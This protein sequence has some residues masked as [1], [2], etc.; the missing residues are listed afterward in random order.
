M[1]SQGVWSVNGV[2]DAAD[3]FKI[4]EKGK[5]SATL[6][7][8]SEHAYPVRY[9]QINRKKH[10]FEIKMDELHNI[11]LSTFKDFVNVQV[12]IHGRGSTV[13]GLMGEFGTGRLL[14]RDGRT[15]LQDINAFGQV[16]QVKAEEPKLFR[17]DRAP[18][19]PH[20]KCRLPRAS[21]GADTKENKLLWQAATKACHE[22]AHQNMD[23]CIADIL[24][25]G[26]LEVVENGEY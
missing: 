24:A 3:E 22:H 26:D 9:T 20:E 8:M 10:L 15:V 6:P 11:T 16:W 5:E 21:A 7:A 12:N 4:S 14:A 19:A 2:D 25:T 1:S 13:K 23:A 17:T 18:Q